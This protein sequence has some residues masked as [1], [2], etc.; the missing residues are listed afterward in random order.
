MSKVIVDTDVVSYA[1]R[2]ATEYA[3]YGKELENKIAYISFMTWAE[4][5]RGSLSRK[6]GDKR[7]RKLADFVKSTYVVIESKEA[8]NRAWGEVI[9]EAREKGR[10][11]RTADAWIAATA[12]ATGVPLM[13]NNRADFECL[14]SIQLISFAPE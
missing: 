5:M 10:V 7:R 11:I 14:D 3:P 12:A 8:I 9:E 6:W 1:F 13:S 2:E 4:L